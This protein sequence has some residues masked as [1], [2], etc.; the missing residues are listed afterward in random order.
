MDKQNT[1]TR[2]KEQVKAKLQDAQEKKKT[3]TLEAIDLLVQAGKLLPHLPPDDSK[4]SERNATL[5]HGTEEIL[6]LSKRGNIL[7]ELEEY[8]EAGTCYKA[9]KDM[10]PNVVLVYKP[11]GDCFRKQ[12]NYNEAI[13]EY[14]QGLRVYGKDVS[15]IKAQK[16][17]L[18]NSK[19]L[20]YLGLKEFEQARADFDAA[21]K[22]N[23]K[24]P[25]YHCNKG[26]AAYALKDKESALNHF[27][28]ASELVKSNQLGDLT[29]HNITYIQKTLQEF[30]HE[31]EALSEISFLEKDDIMASRENDFVKNAVEAI[32]RAE[33]TKDST[34]GEI[35]IKDQ[36]T[37][38]IATKT[39]LSKI[40]SDK[41]LI[42]YY[43][44]FMFT[45]CQSYATAVIVNSGQLVIDTSSKIDVLIKGISLLPLVGSQLS[46]GINSVKDFV[47]GAQTTKAASYV[48]NFATTQTDFD[49]IAQDALCPVILEKES[50]LKSLNEDHL[51]NVLL[52]SW[53]RRFQKVVNALQKLN[54][55]AELYLYGTRN[56]TPL[57][58]FGY[59]A[60]NTV[61][62][63]YIA[64]GKIY[65]GMPAITIL[66]PEK[67]EKLTGIVRNVIDGSFQANKNIEELRK[68]SST[69]KS[70]TACQCQTFSVSEIIYDNPLLN[71]TETFT[72]LCAKFGV[73]RVLEASDLLNKEIR[74]DKLSGQAI[75]DY[76][77]LLDLNLE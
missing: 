16:A 41:Q 72:K 58:K 59:Q 50:E 27:K 11:Y 34:A 62:S 7:Y 37:Q 71:H 13:K 63:D 43:D 49:A 4:G 74:Q 47:K 25:L 36:G 28:Q 9:I 70:T 14:E 69:Q 68:Q 61:V 5:G 51:N 67:L 21:I 46:D 17:G 40:K 76:L 12:G 42:Q 52:P 19:G 10:L 33:G 38:L 15:P 2:L 45:L 73:N 64:S 29:T 53:A 30:I 39:I 35:S 3:N 23:G 57:Q 1:M 55:K 60:A 24:N 54:E 75:S 22:I 77:N 26:H 20:A 31:L 18:L 65:G 56:E 48:C 44:G 8:Q 6:Y 32:S 66:P